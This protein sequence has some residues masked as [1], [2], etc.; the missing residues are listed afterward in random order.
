MV[1]SYQLYLSILVSCLLLSFISSVAT[2]MVSCDM[3]GSCVNNQADSRGG[4]SAGATVAIV[5]AAVFVVILVVIL[6]RILWKGG[7]LGR[8]HLLVR[9]DYKAITLNI[10]IVDHLAETFRN[11]Q[12]K[13]WFFFPDV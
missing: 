10:I 8:K 2:F 4:I 5:A 6:I 3:C 12:A 11:S 7:C 1:L 13:N 9:G